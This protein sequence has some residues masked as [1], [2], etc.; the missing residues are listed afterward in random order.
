[1]RVVSVLFSDYVVNPGVWSALPSSLLCS[2]RSRSSLFVLACPCLHAPLCINCTRA[3]NTQ[4]ASST[5]RDDRPPSFAA[6]FLFFSLSPRELHV[7]T[8]CPLRFAPSALSCPLFPSSPCSPPRN[9]FAPVAFASPGLLRDGGGVETREC[10]LPP[11]SLRASR[12]GRESLRPHAPPKAPSI[13]P[14]TQH[15]PT[16]TLLFAAPHTPHLSPRRPLCFSFAS[17]AH[18]PFEGLSC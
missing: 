6:L 11:A 5:T 15:T 14:S 17:P 18:A 16:R 12:S 13:R 7:G 1:M 3:R 2:V 8:L 9:A 10:P 4:R